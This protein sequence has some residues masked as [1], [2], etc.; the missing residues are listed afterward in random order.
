MREIGRMSVPELA[1]WFE[2]AAEILE[3]QERAR[4]EASGG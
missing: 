1:A 4:K 3:E 2:E